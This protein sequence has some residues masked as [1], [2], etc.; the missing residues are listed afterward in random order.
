MNK[1][2]TM[3]YE[4]LKKQLEE[5]PI[6]YPSKTGT[7]K[8]NQLISMTAAQ[9]I[10]RKIMN[11]AFGRLQRG[12]YS[13]KKDGLYV[14]IPAKELKE[15]IKHKD[16]KEDCNLYR[17]IKGAC[18]PLMKKIIGYTNDESKAF[19][20]L[21]LINK[22]TYEDGCLTLRFPIEI[23]PMIKS[24]KNNG[25]YTFLPDNVIYNLYGKY[26]IPLYEHLKKVCFYN[27]SAS[28]KNNFHFNY[29]I[30]LSELK[31]DIGLVN[32]DNKEIKD[33]ISDQ[34]PTPEMYD[35]ALSKIKDQKYKKWGDFERYVL[36][37]AVEE[38][39]ENTDLYVEYEPARTGIGGEVKFVN[40]SIIRTDESRKW[41][42]RQEKTDVET[43]EAASEDGEITTAM[44][45]EST[46]FLT[47]YEW[48]D[49]ISPS[50]IEAI[51]KKCNGDIAKL[52]K[53]AEYLNG[54][55]TDT[56][57]SIGGWLLSCLENE[58]YKEEPLPRSKKAN[59]KKITEERNINGY[60]ME[61]L[62]KKL[63]E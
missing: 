60:T 23:E 20:Y 27:T 2:E 57:K 61:E 40:F 56:I 15:R 55:N 14:T 24:K 8:D 62:E 29:Q 45:I 54:K 38:I 28:N 25:N 58:W 17:K 1:N 6:F 21:V 16:G 7:K 3:E 12:E 44:I 5:I 37:E 52:K 19:T 34:I 32:I 39:N 42:E 30:C 48:G 53:A 13:S 4:T 46:K 51:T 18:M 47:Q 35:L 49:Y 22:A 10:E 59:E 9:P 11:H 36:R 43:E 50:E 31:L 33:I 26:T 41:I 63:L